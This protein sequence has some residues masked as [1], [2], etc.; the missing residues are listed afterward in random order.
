MEIIVSSSHHAN[1][2]YYVRDQL[3]LELLSCQSTLQSDGR[4]LPPL[5]TF[6]SLAAPKFLLPVRG[7]GLLYL[8]KS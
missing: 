5:T 4:R 1:S 8:E 6:Q 7:L 3:V 2:F